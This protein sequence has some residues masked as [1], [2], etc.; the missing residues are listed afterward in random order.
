MKK[1]VSIIGARSNPKMEEWDLR[2]YPLVMWPYAASLE[3]KYLGKE[4]TFI[5]TN[6]K[7]L[8]DTLLT[9]Y[10]SVNLQNNL[11]DRPDQYATSISTD[12]EW[13]NHAVDWWQLVKHMEPDIIVHLRATTP[14]VTAK[15]I[16]EAIS[17]F[18]QMPEATSLRS[19]HALNE[20]PHKMFIKDG[21]YWKSF[22]QGEGEFFNRPRQSFPHV[23]HPNGY[24]DIV[25]PSVIKSGKL[26]GDKIFAFET[27][28]VIEIDKFEDLVELD[29]HLTYNDEHPT[30]QFMKE[31]Y[32]N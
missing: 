14:L 24:V 4:N 25:R 28:K 23:Y 8:K 13:L 19:A 1:I 10:Y 11:I 22:M 29:Q 15:I 6:S 5:S 3:S 12:L 21:D 26:H 27:A 17:M 20:S 2:G 30:Y 16:D 7:K 32:A 31:N 9:K 18:L